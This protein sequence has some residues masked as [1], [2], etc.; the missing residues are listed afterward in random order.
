M[1]KIPIGKDADGNTV[2][3]NFIQLDPRFGTLTNKKLA[4]I[5]TEII[6]EERKEL[7]K[8]K[9]STVF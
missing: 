6:K 2:C 1:I 5:Q 4:A 3:V 9:G 7:A 8:Q